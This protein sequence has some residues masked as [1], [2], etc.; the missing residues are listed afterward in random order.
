MNYSYYEDGHVYLRKEIIEDNKSIT[1]NI[2]DYI[3]TYQLELK[4]VWNIFDEFAC[5]VG[6]ERHLNESNLE[7][8]NRIVFSTK[9]PGNNT[10]EGLKNSIVSELMSL[11]NISQEDIEIEKI[12]PENLI[13]PYK[14]FNSLLDMLSNINR[15][16]LKDKRWD[17]D[18]W[19]Y[20]FK[21]IQ[22]LDNV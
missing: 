19:Q 6:L 5:F 10:E 15:D 20:D 22:F 2:E 17:L 1:I 7:L 21:S 4:N 16:V 18:K 12:T 11:I 9:N 14:E 3:Y 13:K 8:K